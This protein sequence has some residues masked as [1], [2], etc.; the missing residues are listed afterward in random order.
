MVKKVIPWASIKEFKNI[1]VE[2]GNFFFFEDHTH[3]RIYLR[4]TDI[5]LEWQY[6]NIPCAK[7][8]TKEEFKDFL[9]E[10]LE[11]YNK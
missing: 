10:C 3:L 4:S 7:G 5:G 2:K 9:N 11:I 6:Y 1:L 8:T